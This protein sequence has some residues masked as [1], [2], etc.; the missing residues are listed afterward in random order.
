MLMLTR[1]WG[2]AIAA[3]PAPATGQGFWSG[4]QQGKDQSQAEIAR[5]IHDSVVVRGLLC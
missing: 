1:T 2:F 3:G 5:R 4:G